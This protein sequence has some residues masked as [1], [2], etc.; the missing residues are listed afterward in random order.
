MDR[1]GWID[2]P[3]ARPVA[4]VQ[5]QHRF[6][7]LWDGTVTRSVPMLVV[8]PHPPPYMMPYCE[9]Q[10][11]GVWELGPHHLIAQLF[12]NFVPLGNSKC[13]RRRPTLV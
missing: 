13:V 10:S 11:R 1:Q 8:Y 4:S 12:Q 5:D 6:P 9:R 3:L 7:S 2:H